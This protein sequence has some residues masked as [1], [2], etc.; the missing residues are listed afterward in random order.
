M[1]KEQKNRS[2]SLS[3]PNGKN[4]NRGD[5]K[6]VSQ[7]GG[8]NKSNRQTKGNDERGPVR[9]SGTKKVPNSI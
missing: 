1:D 7:P 5:R 3:N 6:Q 9:E 4:E 2:G 8:P